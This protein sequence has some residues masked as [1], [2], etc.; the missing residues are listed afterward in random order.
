MLPRYLVPLFAAI[1]ASAHAA[2]HI[3][4][5]SVD[6][7]R[8][9]GIDR[10]I[11]EDRAPNFER[12]QAEGVWTH[13]ARTDFD[14]TRTLPNNISM[15]TG[16]P[17]EGDLGHGWDEDGNV[18][19]SDTIHRN[20]GSYVASMYDVAHDNG[21]RTAVYR[22]NEKLVIFD[23][24]YDSSNGGSDETGE[25]NGYRKID[26]ERASDEDVERA[27]RLVDQFTADYAIGED[28]IHLSYIHLV[29]PDEAGRDEGYTDDDYFD[30]VARVDSYI[31]Q[32]IQAVESNPTYAGKTT[33]IISSDHGG[34]GSSHSDEE[35]PDNYTVP[36]YVWGED[37]P[38]AADLYEINE[39]TRVDPGD[40][41]PAFALAGQPIRN[42]DI[43]NL[44][45][46]LLDLTPV[47]DS[48]INSPFSLF[49]GTNA[50]D[51]PEPSA[52][53]TTSEHVIVISI[54]GLRP[55]AI[56]EVIEDG[57]GATFER[58][59]AEGV[60]THN[61]RTDYGYTRTMPNNISIVTGRPVAG[62]LGHE[63]TRNNDVGRFDTI[64]RNKDSYVASMFDVAH[65]HGLRTAL[66]RSKEKLIIFDQSYDSSDGANDT[67]GDDNGERKI[68]I[69]RSSDDDPDDGVKTADLLVDKFLADYAVGEDPIH[70][71]YLHLIDPDE[72]GHGD[73]WTMPIYYNA[74]A[75]I[76]T[77]I[78]NVIQT[79]ESNPVYA[80]KTT[81]II[82]TDHGG[83]G[84]SHSDE[85][86]ERNY[87]IPFYVWGASVPRTADLYELNETSRKEPGDSRPEFGFTDQP[88]RNGDIANLAL[89][90][91]GLPAVPGSAINSQQDLSIGVPESITQPFVPS[92]TVDITSDGVIRLSWPSGRDA[93]VQ[94]SDS[95]SNWEDAPGDWPTPDSMWDN[96][97]STEAPRYFRII[98]D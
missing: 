91:L 40:S 69:E 64:H 29:D 44:A 90:V 63:W 24:S 57:R 84:S 43:A 83:E 11:D 41:R 12:L 28:I 48:S 18:S 62:D 4:V 94:M 52:P 77:Y 74:V 98:F 2:D 21:L 46:D 73:R 88:I 34:E 15:V 81:I 61:A 79:L 82:S 70:L 95:L 92:V 75:N 38:T 42:G 55:D 72:V 97:F 68:D 19:R 96:P 14:D 67:T 45:L 22:S 87:T 71:S 10:V 66:Y 27:D 93:T 30:A 7:L 37:V 58:F 51:I 50:V 5:V 13:N 47:P 36:F 23:Q 33:I 8:P 26:F 39:E 59:K 56:D 9:D 25:N 86:E 1:F 60:W 89:N 20:N 53:P 49:V 3:I 31:G 6:G 76:D 80:G 54:D 35:E 85:E 16:R 32:I 17:V 65:D 78:G